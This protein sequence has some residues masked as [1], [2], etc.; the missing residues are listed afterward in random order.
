MEQFI[1]FV[2]IGLT[3]G[4]V[5][6]LAATGL[7]V[8]YKTSGIFNFA[9]GSLA[10][11]S[12]Y[13]YYW[14]THDL[15]MPWWWAAAVSLVVGGPLC[16]FL[17]ELLARRLAD[18]DH[19]IKIAATVGI[20]VA[21][22]AV[23]VILHGGAAPTVEPYLPTGTFEAVGVNIGWDQLIIF[24]IATL[25][26]AGLY[27]YFRW[28][29]SGVAMRAVVDDPALVA[30]TGA[31]PIRIRRTAWII[32]ASFASLSGLLLAPSLSVDGVVLTQLAI[33]AFGAAAIG[34]FTN[35]PLAYVGGLLLGI[36]GAMATKY[37]VS[38]NWLTGLPPALPF[39]VLFAVL[40]V[41]PR[42]LLA[43]RRYLTARRTPDAWHAPPRVRI[44]AG[45]VAVL[46]ACFVPAVVGTKLVVFSAALVAIVLLLSLGL[47]TR[48][49]GQVSL[50]QYG[51]AAI[52]GAATAQ[53]S[54]NVGL[55]WLLALV[56]AGAIT[57]PVGALLAIPAMRL[58][59][60]FLA[61]AT[62]GFGIF[63]EQLLYTTP[64]MFG[65][66]TNGISVG[67][68]DLSIGP[69]DL[70]TDTGYFYLLL[71]FVVVASAATVLVQRSRLGRL[72]S[73]IRDSPVVLETN[74]ASVNTSKVIVFCLSAFMA[75]VAGGLLVSLFGV[76]T[77]SQ[78]SSFSSLTLLVLVVI[79]PFGTPWYA[80]VAGLALQV[81]PAYISSGEVTNYLNVIFGISAVL[82]PY[83]LLSHPGMPQRL[84]RLAWRIDAAL[85]FGRP[86]AEEPVVAVVSDGPVESAQPRGGLTVH[87]LVVRY[88]G[89]VAVE[90][91]SLVA[92]PGRITGL[93][94]PNGAGKTSTFNACSGLL[95]A[96][97]GRIELGGR[98]V[99]RRS[100]AA[101][102]RL[103]LGRTF[104]RVE[105]C[106]SLSVAENLALGRE[107]ALAG[108]NPLRH[109]VPR[110]GDRD[111]VAA[112]VADAAEQAGVGDLLDRDVTSLST[113][114]RR[115]VELARVLAGRYDT[116]LLD[117][118]SSGLDRVETA[119]FAE[120]LTRVVRERRLTM[121]IVEHDMALVR[122][123]CDEVYV[124]DFGRLIYDGAPQEMLASPIVRAA[125]LGSDEVTTLLDAAPVLA[126]GPADD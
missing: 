3:T 7:V 67:R 121:L 104:Q 35:L 95:H 5:I 18:C 63:L 34:Y 126:G 10:A 70:S 120:V 105:L 57:V 25:A 92:R 36:A 2:I 81:I 83:T 69:L 112:A 39:I 99:S 115:L 56:L 60:V 42:R 51:F 31:S 107:S 43:D 113:G 52:G 50:C 86:R 38:I 23:G 9:Q 29:R 6:G 73:A 82:A 47:L 64:L 54:T 123:I 98:E 28:A 74:G 91:L 101:R 32:G 20:V 84:R 68:P 103:G 41:L 109:I 22:I 26:T 116:I 79:I 61:L 8:T 24:V 14:L 1:A 45:A 4:S 122:D 46:I 53:L 17:L 106:Q 88:G 49:S 119:A 94:G 33:Q 90:H 72:L 77:A 93:I 111:V 85:R 96:T 21:V 71:G 12:V 117:E 58:S 76:A 97:A 124:L 19:T 15:G 65:E 11:V 59:G 110:R 30:M 40:I 75:A 13:L 55:P 37:S 78:F 114:Q 80:V 16:G 66:T 108:S 100:A 48:L 27:L 87:D 62:L 44:L 102:A 125:Y 89:N 118:P